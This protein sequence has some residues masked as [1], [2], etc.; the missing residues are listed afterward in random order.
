[1][2]LPYD[3]DQFVRLGERAVAWSYWRWMAGTLILRGD[4]ITERTLGVVP[5]SLPDFTDPA[6]LGCL[7]YLVREAWR[8]PTLH[9]YMVGSE[10]WCVST[11]KGPKFGPTE[12]AAW[13]A[14]GEVAPY[15]ELTKK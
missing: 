15:L 5:G 6:S 10:G 13:L 8:K 9:A 3:Y 7:V 2:A 1:M 14:A 12:V 11:P 4:R